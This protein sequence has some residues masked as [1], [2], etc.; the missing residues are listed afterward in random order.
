MAQ[1]IEQVGGE[2][3]D[4]ESRARAAKISAEQTRTAKYVLCATAD[5]IVQNMPSEDRH[6]WTQ[7]N[8]LSRFFGERVGGVRF[9]E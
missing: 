9:F 5:D 3:Q 6:L 1:L 2:I 8:M 7:H 4:F